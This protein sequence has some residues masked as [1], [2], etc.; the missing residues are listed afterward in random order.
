MFISANLTLIPFSTKLHILV[1]D[2]ALLDLTSSICFLFTYAHAHIRIVSSRWCVEHLITKTTRNGPREHF[3]FNLP[4][5]G[6]LCQHTQSSSKLINLTK[7]ESTFA[8]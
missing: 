4:L 3:P 8:D 1:H 7:Y 5:F 6:D 2:C